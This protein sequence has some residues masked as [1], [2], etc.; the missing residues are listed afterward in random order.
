MTGLSNFCEI[1]SSLPGVEIAIKCD[2]YLSN[3]HEISNGVIQ[4]GDTLECDRSIK[5]S[6]NFH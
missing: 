6:W 5:I 2:L 4:A 3:F 1:F